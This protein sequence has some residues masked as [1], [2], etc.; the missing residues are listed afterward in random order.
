[1]IAFLVNLQLD[2]LFEDLEALITPDLD[3][4]LPDFLFFHLDF[5]IFDSIRS[6][7]SDNSGSL[8]HVHGEVGAVSLLV[9]DL[10]VFVHHVGVKEEDLAAELALVVD[11]LDDLIVWVAVQPL[12]FRQ[13]CLILEA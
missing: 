11:H 2:I 13:C 1:M 8:P 5:F 6:G 3:E 4:I 7:L 12:V 10:H 9:D